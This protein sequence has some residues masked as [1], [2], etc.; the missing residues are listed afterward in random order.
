MCLFQEV[1]LGKWSLDIFYQY[2]SGWKATIS[3]SS[4]SAVLQALQLCGKDIS[5]SVMSLTVMSSSGRVQHDALHSRTDSDWLWCELE[6]AKGRLNRISSHKQ[7]S[8]AVSRS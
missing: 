2:C 8:C 7:I 6:E 3:L 1:G 5:T 4:L